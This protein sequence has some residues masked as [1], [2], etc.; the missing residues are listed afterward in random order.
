MI[1]RKF[2]RYN[3]RVQSICNQRQNENQVPFAALK[4]KLCKIT[5]FRINRAYPDYLK[6]GIPEKEDWRP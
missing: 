3:A 5:N 1:D 4:E 2:L 6:N